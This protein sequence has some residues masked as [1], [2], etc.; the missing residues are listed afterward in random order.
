MP[1]IHALPV[2]PCLLGESPLWHRHQQVL[3][4]CDIP[5][6]RLHR[7]EPSNS[8]HR[9][10][11]FETDVACC[12]AI[13]GSDDLLLGMRDGLWRFHPATGE[14]TL[15]A[16]APYDTARERFNDGKADPQGRFWVGTIYEP[17]DPPLAALYCLADGQLTRRADGIVTSNGLAVSPDQRTMYWT[18]TKAHTIYAWDFDAATGTIA[19]RRDFATFA[20]KQ[21]G[22]GLDGYGGRPDGAAVDVEGAYWVA[23]FEGRQV[24][25]LSPQGEVLQ[26]LRLPA[27]CPTMV[28]F[29]DE[30]LRTLYITTARHGRS[31]EELQALPLSGCVLRVRVDV[32]GEPIAAVRL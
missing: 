10:W 3:W 2:E 25:R 30:D 21:A 23:M 6:H 7:W 13:E 26:A 32:A 5:G 4:W 17:R 22:Q 19:G 24:L 16:A 11:T 31:A 1:D 15:L 12:A 18:D 9:V 14:R 29:G 27:Q 28:A 8:R 20:P